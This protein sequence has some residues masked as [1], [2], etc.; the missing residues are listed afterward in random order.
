MCL[1]FEKKGLSIGV[2]SMS[3]YSPTSN[4]Y[5][6][7]MAEVFEGIPGPGKSA[8]RRNLTDPKLIEFYSKS[9]IQSFRCTRHSQ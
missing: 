5:F 9:S 4:Q 7:P 1:L 2:A 6:V 3:I 8:V